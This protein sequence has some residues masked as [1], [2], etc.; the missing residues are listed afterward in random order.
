MR[1]LLAVKVPKQLPLMLMV[2][3]ADGTQWNSES[4]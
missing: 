1:A 4:R 3:I 2:R